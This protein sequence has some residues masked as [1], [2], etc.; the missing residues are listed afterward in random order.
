M[1][2]RSEPRS[3]LPTSEAFQWKIFIEKRARHP[4]TGTTGIAT[5]TLISFKDCNPKTWNVEHDFKPFLALKLKAFSLTFSRKINRSFLAFKTTRSTQTNCY[6]KIYLTYSSS[7]GSSKPTVSSTLIQNREVEQVLTI[8]PSF[9]TCDD[10]SGSYNFFEKIV[11][12][13]TDRLFGEQENGSTK[14]TSWPEGDLSTNCRNLV[15]YFSV[16]NNKLS[17]P[18]GCVVGRE[19]ARKT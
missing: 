1:A 19:A 17:W 10:W 12:L 9:G 14:S 15:N 16:E 3:Q 4:F 11:K 18:G 6:W 13:I 8:E 7:T 5:S 2:K